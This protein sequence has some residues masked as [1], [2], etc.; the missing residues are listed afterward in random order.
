[1]AEFK[2]GGLVRSRAGHDKDQLYIIIGVSKE[3]VN[4]SDGKHRPADRPKRKNKKHL[5]IIHVYDE[6]FGKK[7][8]DSGRVPDEAVRAFIRAHKE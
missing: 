1:M 5:Q 4:L 8:E 2:I 6:T 3:Y 7:L